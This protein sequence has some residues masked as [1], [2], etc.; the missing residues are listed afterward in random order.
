MFSY[1]HWLNDFSTTKD[2][3]DITSIPS[4]IG[5]LTSL[6]HLSLCECNIDSNF[7]IGNQW[8]KYGIHQK[9]FLNYCI[10]CFLF[11][12]DFLISKD[13]NSLTSIPTEIGMLTDLTALDLCECITNFNLWL[14][15]ND[16]GIEFIRNAFS[17]F[18][19]FVY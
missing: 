4:E 9:Y 15:T 11:I 3:N 8:F 13:D 19:P 18:V 5:M 17:N 7:F 16:F 14:I 10:I 12:V 2:D 6:T 1:L